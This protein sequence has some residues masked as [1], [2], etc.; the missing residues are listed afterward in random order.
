MFASFTS[1]GTLLTLGMLFSVVTFVVGCAVGGWFVRS[2]RTQSDA[3]AS[4]GGNIHMTRSI[5]RAVMASERIHDLARHVVSHVGD[6]GS[7]VE[8]F[9]SD[10]RAMAG[11]QTSIATDTLLLA[12]GQMTCANTELQQRL[13][14]IEKQI[15]S[16]AA[17]LRTYGSEARTDSVT[18]LANRRAFD[19]EIQRRFA[20]WQRRRTPFTLMILDADNFKKINDT[21]GHQTGDEA[22]RQIG[23]V[24]TDSSR[25][26]DFRCRYGGDEFIVIMPDSGTQEAR[27]AAER[28]RKAIESIT[29]EAGGQSLHLTCSVG[30]ARIGANDDAARLVRRADEALYKSKDAGRNCGHWHDGNESLPLSSD[31]PNSA[32]SPAPLIET[33]ADR[34][35][36]VDAL[37]RRLPE[38][39]RF[40]L[41]L[42]IIELRVANYTTL[43]ETYGEADARTTLDAVAAFTQLAL[44]QVDLL[45]RLDDGEF[46]VL[47][48]GSTRTEAN[49]IAKRL[50]MSAANCDARLHNEKVHIDVTHGIA[51]FR[52]NDTAESMMARARLAADAEASRAAAVKILTFCDLNS[53]IASNFARDSSNCIGLAALVQME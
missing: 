15:A 7:K 33:L 53:H 37:S 12:I 23:Q 31:G 51:E 14:R 32:S 18:G 50:H 46:A 8:A 13:A 9:N 44:R 19:D 52:P 35:A 3:A 17:E 40:G 38:S 48:P 36:F 47:L 25:Q 2:S 4:N 45:A 30:V 49:Q 21:Y 28:I 24:I 1:I 43:C 11:Q 6:H 39:Q 42:S 20:E 22:L 26:M 10:I 5:E 29:I 34:Q 16:Q 41:P 27:T